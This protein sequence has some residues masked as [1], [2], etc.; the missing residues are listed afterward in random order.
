VVTVVSL[1]RDKVGPRVFTAVHR[2]TYL[3][4]PVALLHALGN[5]T[6]AG[7]LWMD[8]VAI[9]CSLAV[10]ASVVWRLLPSYAE[11]GNVRTP[12]TVAR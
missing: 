3:L 5:G 12:R 6:D 4:W 10:G 11:R 8:A 9:V 7:T 1:L 2:L